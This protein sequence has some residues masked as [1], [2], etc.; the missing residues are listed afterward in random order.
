MSGLLSSVSLRH[1]VVQFYLLLHDF[2]ILYSK[3]NI[4]KFVKKD[5]CIDHLTFSCNQ[6]SKVFAGVPFLKVPAYHS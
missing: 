6:G 3:E 5:K 1:C 2:C 4:S